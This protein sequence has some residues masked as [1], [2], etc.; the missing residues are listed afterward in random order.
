MDVYDVK[1]TYFVTVA[2]CVCDVHCGILCVMLI[3]YRVCSLAN[4]LSRHRPFLSIENLNKV[5]ES[6]VHG[7]VRV[8]QLLCFRFTVWVWHL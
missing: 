2:L 1:L 4:L 7:R 8:S 6:Q 5:G 3:P